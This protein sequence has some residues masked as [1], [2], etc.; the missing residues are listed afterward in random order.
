MAA[1]EDYL[2]YLER[3]KAGG[4]GRKEMDQVRFAELS[5]EY[6]RLMRRIDPHDIQ[7]DEWKRGDELRFLLILHEDEDD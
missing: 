5:E 4:A 1:H 6:E 7:L 2:E 3:H